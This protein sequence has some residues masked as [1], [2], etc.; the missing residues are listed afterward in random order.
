MGAW[1]NAWMS[2]WMN[3]WMDKWIIPAYDPFH[4]GNPTPFGA[5]SCKIYKHM[6][7][8]CSACDAVLKDVNVIRFLID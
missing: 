6:I 7:V 3:E 4:S 5:R 1:K 8:G 2:E